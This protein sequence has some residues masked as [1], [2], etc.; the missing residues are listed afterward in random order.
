LF[1]AFNILGV[2]QGRLRTVA[3]SWGFLRICHPHQN[4]QF[5]PISFSNLDDSLKLSKPK[6][7]VRPIR[8]VLGDI[9]SGLLEGGTLA[10]ADQFNKIVVDA[11]SLA[12]IDAGVPQNILETDIARNVGKVAAPCSMMIASNALGDR[13][14]GSDLIY[15]GSQKA[16]SVAS[17]Q[18][19]LPALSK[20]RPKFKRLE[21]A[22]ERLEPKSLTETEIMPDP[23]QSTVKKHESQKTKELRSRL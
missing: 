9:G 8:Q 6:T 13:M 23:V 3:G 7:N 4:H 10:A 14:P 17:L 11:I 2:F 18:V 20:L 16:L 1:S 15:K 21:E 12:L 19:I 5:Y 22:A